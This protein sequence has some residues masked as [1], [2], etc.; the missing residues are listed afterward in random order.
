[1][2]DLLH[3]ARG[4]GDAMTRGEIAA[5]LERDAVAAQQTADAS[6]GAPNEFYSNRAT[7]CRE[8]AAIL[9]AVGAQEPAPEVVPQPLPT[10]TVAMQYQYVGKLKPRPFDD[11]EP[12]P[13]APEP[14]PWIP[15]SVRLPEAIDNYD[16]TF[17]FGSM[18]GGTDIAY[19]NGKR[20][21][22][23]Q[24]LPFE[25]GGY[26]VWAWKPRPAPYSP[27]AKP[28]PQ[29]CVWRPGSVLGVMSTGCGWTN[30][31]QPVFCHQCGKP[32]QIAPEGRTP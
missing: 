20:W 16:V 31:K 21:T 26:R 4:E 13:S 22:D 1:M 27:D 29:V 23:D 19:W 14:S 12:A 3:A 28:E 18:L 9:R 10:R 17:G 8:A 7:A 2:G 24:G 30:R 11:D 15:V 25:E 6:M 32:I 5:W